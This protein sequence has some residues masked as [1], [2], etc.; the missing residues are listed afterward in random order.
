VALTHE[1][2]E[3]EKYPVKVEHFRKLTDHFRVFCRIFLTLR[4]ANLRMSTCNR[5]DLQIVGISTDF[6]QKPPR[7]TAAETWILFILHI[8]LP[9]NRGVT[10][11]FK[12]WL[13]SRG[14]MSNVQVI[15]RSLKVDS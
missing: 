4:K 2:V 6:A 9:F 10:W 8:L 5:S 13:V 15:R 3:F 12:Q 1:P 11:E 7:I 14:S